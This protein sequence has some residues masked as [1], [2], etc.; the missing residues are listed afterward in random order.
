MLAYRIG[1][2]EANSY[3][4]SPHWSQIDGVAMHYQLTGDEKSRF[5]VGRVAEILRYFRD[6]ASLVG[7]PDIESR[8][9]AR[10][11]MAQLWGWRLQAR[12]NEAIA[13]TSAPGTWRRA[14]R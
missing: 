8:I 14:G 13:T 5:A 2:L 7:H 3:G 9:L 6:R 10:A 11:L 12:G 1:Y 4:T